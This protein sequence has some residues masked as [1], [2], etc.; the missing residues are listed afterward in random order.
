MSGNVWEWC[1]DWFGSYPAGAQ[2]YPQGAVRG[3]YHVFRGGGWD[4][5]SQDCRA[6]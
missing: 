4:Y 2:N 5:G 6:A 3:V 1:W